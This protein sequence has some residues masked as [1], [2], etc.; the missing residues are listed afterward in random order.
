MADVQKDANCI[1]IFF[2]AYLPYSHVEDVASDRA[3]YSHV[4]ETFLGNNDTGDE[5]GY[6][7]ASGQKCNAHH[8]NVKMEASHW[9]E[10]GYSITGSRYREKVSTFHTHR[11]KIQDTFA[12]VLM[13]DIFIS[14]KYFICLKEV[15]EY[16]WF[17]SLNHIKV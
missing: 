6:T 4:T 10:D 9:I 5:I 2:V 13:C 15:Q 11:R 8:L 7:C 1:L 17:T 16:D 14:Y 12:K 3:G